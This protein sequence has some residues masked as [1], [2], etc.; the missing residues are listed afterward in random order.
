MLVLLLSA[1]LLPLN[2]A[3]SGFC[4]ALRGRVGW[5]LEHSPLFFLFSLPSLPGTA[6]V[7]GAYST[8]EWSTRTCQVYM[9]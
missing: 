8:L 4:V 5:R 7:P 9:I 3:L 2:R 6:A 1:L